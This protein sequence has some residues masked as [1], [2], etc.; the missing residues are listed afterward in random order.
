MNNR[1]P[2]IQATAKLDYNRKEIEERH[3]AVAPAVVDPRDL[4][5][6]LTELLPE[7]S[8]IVWRRAFS[9]ISSAVGGV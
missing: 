2:P 4:Y 7:S 8:Y 3:L 6:A 1:L 9:Y 5:L